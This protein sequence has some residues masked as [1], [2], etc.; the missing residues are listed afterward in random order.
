MTTTAQTPT[1]TAVLVRRPARSTGRGLRRALLSLLVAA[2]AVVGV[3]LSPAAAWTQTGANGYPGQIVPRGVAAQGYYYKAPGA[4][5]GSSVPHLNVRG[6][7]AYRSP[8]TSGY[9]SVTYQFRV[10][11]WDGYRWVLLSWNLPVTQGIPQGYGSTDFA[12]HFLLKASAPGYYRVTLAVSWFDA[13]GRSLGSRA[14][15]YD[16]IDYVCGMSPCTAGRGW[17]YA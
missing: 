17:I 8:A 14:V 15:D 13:Y 2:I 9:Q 11:R 6:L 12:P 10:H 5:Y 1:S 4:L 16:G 3:N 7:V